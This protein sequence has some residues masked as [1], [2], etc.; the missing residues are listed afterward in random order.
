[1]AVST[2][3][4]KCNDDT[5]CAFA[6]AHYCELALKAPVCLPGHATVTGPHNLV[7]FAKQTTIVA[8]VGEQQDGTLD[9]VD[10]EGAQLTIDP[11]SL[12]TTLNGGT[13]S[14][15]FDSQTSF[16]YHFVAGGP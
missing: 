1:S 13:A 7:P 16:H 5:D 14:I 9:V 12:V 3:G 10:P 15:A 4:K 8:Q 11:F 2:T 6:A